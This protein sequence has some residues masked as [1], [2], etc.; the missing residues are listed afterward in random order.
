M[1]REWYLLRWFVPVP[2]SVF[3][4]RPVP[5][6]TSRTATVLLL[7]EFSEGRRPLCVVGLHFWTTLRG[8]F[9]SGLLQAQLLAP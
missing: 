9:G 3:D 4:C 7:F 5:R 2:E 6:L 1:R 8:R